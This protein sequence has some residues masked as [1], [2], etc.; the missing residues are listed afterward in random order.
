MQKPPQRS[1]IQLSEEPKVLVETSVQ[2]SAL[3]IHILRAGRYPKK[4]DKPSRP[5]R[6]YRGPVGA[7]R[8]VRDANATRSGGI[9]DE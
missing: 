2:I 3:G 1:G 9:S 6:G 7:L 4:R 5:E 8:L